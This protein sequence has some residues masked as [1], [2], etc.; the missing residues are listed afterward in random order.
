MNEPKKIKAILKVEAVMETT[1]E[2][3]TAETVRFCIDEDLKDFGWQIDSCEVLQQTPST[4][5][6]RIQS[7]SVDVYAKWIY[8]YLAETVIIYDLL[9]TTYEKYMAEN[10]LGRIQL[11]KQWLLQESR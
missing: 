7:M 2:E 1:N 10:R 6:Q 4:K 11:I 8:D 5:H 3:D 9:K